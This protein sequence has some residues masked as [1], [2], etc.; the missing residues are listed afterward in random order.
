[1]LGASSDRVARVHRTD[2][3]PPP[4]GPALDAAPPSVAFGIWQ[5][6]AGECSAAVHDRYSTIG[7]DGK[8]YPTWHPPVDPLSG[9]SFG[10]EH[11]RDP[12]GSALYREVGDLPFGY[13][14]EQL[15]VAN[16]GMRRHE[17]HVGHK[18]E[19]ENDIV[20]RSGRR[21]GSAA[22]SAL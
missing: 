7:P 13:V 3:R 15:D 8:R 14:N 18:I 5:P 12:R 21:R 2:E 6:A 10:H 1:M 17:D 4:D 19:W 20:L 11:G 9:C 16:L 22:R